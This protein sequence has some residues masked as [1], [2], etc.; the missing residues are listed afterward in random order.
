M[1]NYSSQHRDFLTPEVIFTTSIFKSNFDLKLFEFHEKEIAIIDPQQ[2][3]LLILCH[4]ILKRDQNGKRNES[5]KSVFVG[6]STSE[7]SDLTPRSLNELGS[8][9]SATASAL[10]VASGRVSFCF[11]LRGPSMSIDTACSSSLVAMHLG[12]KSCN[13]DECSASLVCGVNLILLSR[14]TEIFQR[15]GMLSRDGRCKTL[16][17]TADGYVRSEGCE[18]L[19]LIRGY[20]GLHTV[21]VSGSAVNQ[22]GRS[23]SLTA[24][25]GPSQRVVIET[26]LENA[27]ADA[28]SLSK[29]YMHGT[30]TSLGD[31]IEIGGILSVVGHFDR[32]KFSISAVKTY[33]GH[34]ECASG[35]SSILCAVQQLEYSHRYDTTIISQNVSIHE[36]EIQR[37]RE[38]TWRENCTTYGIIH[39]AGILRDASI[40]RQSPEIVRAVFAPK[41]VGYKNIINPINAN[42]FTIAFS[43]ITAQIPSIGQ[44]NYSSANAT[45]DVLVTKNF[46]SGLPVCSI[47]WG[48][49]DIYEI[50]SQAVF[51]TIGK[52]V[53]A[54]QPLM[55]A[56]IDSLVAS[57]L[58]N[59]LSTLLNIFIPTTIAF[60]YPTMMDPQQRLLLMEVLNSK[61]CVK[62]LTDCSEILP[63]V[64]VY[65]GITSNYFNISFVTKFTHYSATGQ[66]PSVASGR[67]SYIFGWIGPAL[68]IDTACSSSLVG[69]HQGFIYC[70]T[71]EYTTRK[72][73]VC[74]GCHIITSQ[75]STMLCDAAGMLSTDGR[76][77]ALDD[78]ADGYVRGEA[79][80][81][82]TIERKENVMKSSC[83][84]TTTVNQDGRSSALTAP[85]GYAQYSII[86]ESLNSICTDAKVA[87]NGAELH[88]TGTV[89]GDPIEL[90]SIQKA[91]LHYGK[92]NEAIV[93]SAI[94]S[95]LG[96]GETGAGI[97]SLLCGLKKTFKL[98]RWFGFMMYFTSGTSG[99]SKGVIL[100]HNSICNHSVGVTDAMRLTR[101]DI[102]LHAAPMF[103]L[104]DAFAIYAITSVGGSHILQEE[105]DAVDTLRIIENEGVTALNLSSTMLSIID[106]NPIL[107]VLDLSS[108]RIISCGGSSFPSSVARH[109]LA[110]LGCEF[111]ISYGMTECCGKVSMSIL[112]IKFRISMPLSEQMRA[113]LSSGRPFALQNIRIV[114]NYSEESAQE[115]KCVIPGSSEVGEVQCKGPTAIKNY[116]NFRHENKFTRDGWLRTGD[117]AMVDSRGFL[118]ILDR[119]IDMV[120]IGSENVYCSEVEAALLEH[121]SIVQAAVFGIPNAILGEELC[122]YVMWGKSYVSKSSLKDIYSFMRSRVADFKVPSVIRIVHKIPMNYAQMC[123]LSVNLSN[124]IRAKFGVFI[125]I[126]QFEYGFSLLQTEKYLPTSFAIGNSHSVSSGRISFFFDFK[127]PSISVDTACSSSHV[128][129][130]LLRNSLLKFET[131]AGISGS[132]N[133]C[134]NRKL[135]M[136]FSES[137]MLSVDGRCKVLD[138][139]ADGYVR[140]EFCGVIFAVS[141]TKNNSELVKPQIG[142]TVMNQDGLSSSLTAP[143]GSSQRALIGEVLR[144]EYMNIT[145]Q[146][147]H[148][149][150]TGTPLGDPIEINA[151]SDVMDCKK[152]RKLIPLNLSAIK[153]SLGHAEVAA[154]MISIISLISELEL[155]E[156]NYILHLRSINEHLNVQSFNSIMNSKVY[157][158]YP[159]INDDCRGVDRF[160]LCSSIV[161]LLGS[162]G[163]SNYAAANSWL[164]TYSN[165]RSYLGIN[166]ISIQWG[167]WCCQQ[168]MATFKV[169]ARMIRLGLGVISSKVGLIA[170][171]KILSTTTFPSLIENGVDSLA[172]VEISNLIGAEFGVTLPDIGVFVGISSSD[173][174]RMLNIQIDDISPFAASGGAFSVAAGR[175]SFCFAL[176]GPS[177]A[178]DTACSS[179]LV[180]LHVCIRISSTTCECKGNIVTGVNLIQLLDTTLIFVSAGMISKD[181]R[182]K[183]L[184][185]SADGYV[186]SE[187]CSS[188][189][190]Q[191]DIS[192]PNIYTNIDMYVAISGSCVNQ[193]GR[194]SSLNAPS[195]LAQRDCIKHVIHM[196]RHM[197]KSDENTPI[198]SLHGTG[199][200]LGDPIETSAIQKILYEEFLDGVKTC[201]RPMNRFV[202]LAATKSRLGHSE[203]ASGILSV[204]HAIGGLSRIAQ[205]VFYS[206][207]QNHDFY[208]YELISRNAQKNT[209]YFTSSK[210]CISVQ[211]VDVAMKADSYDSYQRT[212]ATLDVLTHA[213]GSLCDALAYNQSI[214][215]FSQVLSPKV[216]GL[217]TVSSWLSTIPIKKL[218]IFSSIS[219]TLG[220]MSQSNYAAANGWMDSWS[221]RNYSSGLNVISIEWGAWNI[222]GGMANNSVLKNSESVEMECSSIDPQH[223]ILLEVVQNARAQ[224]SMLLSQ[225]GKDGVIVGI[226]SNEFCQISTMVPKSL[227][228]TGGFLSV[229]CGRISYVYNF[230]GP[231]MCIDTA[232]SSSLVSLHLSNRTLTKLLIRIFSGGVNI[233]LLQSTSSMFASAG[234]LSSDGRCKVLDALA[235]GYVRSEECIIALLANFQEKDHIVIEV[236][237]S[238]VSQDGRSSSLTAPNGPSQKDC[239]NMAIADISEKVEVLEFFTFDLLQLHG[240]GTALGDPIEFGAL[241]GLNNVTSKNEP[242]VVSAS[243][244]RSGHKE[245]ASGLFGLLYD[246]LLNRQNCASLRVTNAPKIDSMMHLVSFIRLFPLSIITMSSISSLLVSPGQLNYAASNK[247]MNSWV[248]KINVQG[249]VGLSIKFGAWNGIEG[250]ATKSTISRLEKGGV[251]YLSANEAIIGDVQK[252]LEINEPFMDSGLDSLGLLELRQSVM[253]HFD[254]DLPST[255]SFDYPTVGELSKYILSLMS[256]KNCVNTEIDTIKAK[257]E[258]K[259]EKFTFSSLILFVGVL[260]PGFV[261]EIESFWNVLMSG[262][263]NIESI[264]QRRFDRELCG[265][266]GRFAAFL[267]QICYF[268]SIL[269]RYSFQESREMD[270]QQRILLESCLKYFT[271]S[272]KT[273]GYFQGYQIGIYLGVMWTE[274]QHLLRFINPDRKSIYLGTGNGLSF[275]LGR[276]SFVFGLNGP[277]CITDT[278]CSS[279]LVALHLSQHALMSAECIEA[280]VGGIQCMIL[281]ETFMIMNNLKALSS[282]SRCKTLDVSANGYGRGEGTT[283]LYLGSYDEESLQWHIIRIRGSSVNQDGRS[284]SFTS[285]Y[286]PSQQNLIKD[287]LK[288]SNL[289]YVAGL[290]SLH[291]TGTSLGDPIE[292]SALKEVC[293][294]DSSQYLTFASSKSFFGHTEGAAGLTGLIL[295]CASIFHSACPE[296][297]FCRNL[298]PHMIPNIRGFISDLTPIPLR[299]QDIFRHSKELRIAVKA[300]GLNFRDILNVLGMYPGDPG[301]PGSDF[302]GTVLTNQSSFKIG[303]SVF[304]LSAGCLGTIVEVLQTNCAHKPPNISHASAAALPTAMIT[305][306]LILEKLNNLD[307]IQEISHNLDRTVLLHG[308]SGGVGLTTAQLLISNGYTVIGSAS[309]ARKRF[310]MRTLGFNKMTC[311]RTTDFVDSVTTNTLGVGV[312][313]VINSL[314]SPGMIAASLSVLQRNGSFIEIGKREI[315]S[316]RAANLEKPT[317]E[318]NLIATDFLSPRDIEAR[319]HYL[320]CALCIGTMKP[321]PSQINNFNAV[322]ESMR[323]MAH[324]N[325]IGKIIV[326]KASFKENLSLKL[327]IFGGLGYLGRLMTMWSN[328]NQVRKV[329]L[330]SRLARFRKIQ[331]NLFCT[332]ALMGISK[333]KI[334]SFEEVRQISSIH[335]SFGNTIVNASGLLRDGT[336]ELQSFNT[337]SIVITPKCSGMHRVIK[338][339]ESR[340]PI[341][342]YIFFSSI[343]TFLASPGQINYV[344][345]NASLDNHARTIQIRGH[346]CVSIQWGGWEGD[347][348]MANS[349]QIVK[350]KRS[351]IGSINPMI[352]L[353]LLDITIASLECTIS[354][355]TEC[356]S[357]INPFDW[358]TVGDDEPLVQSGIDSLGAIEL[359]NSLSRITNIDL[360]STLIFDHPTISSIASH[361]EQHSMIEKNSQ[362]FNENSLSL[363][364]EDDAE[365]A[366]NYQTIEK[367]SYSM[368]EIYT[369]I[370]DH[371][372][373]VPYERW[374]IDDN[375]STLSSRFGFFLLNIESF[376]TEIFRV[377]PPEATLMDPQQRILLSLVYN[378]KSCKNVMYTQRTGVTVG[379]SGSEYGRL[380]SAVNV[381]TATGG[382]LS[383][384]SGRISYIFGLQGICVSVDTACSS[385]L[386]GLHLAISNMVISE[387]DASISCGSNVTLSNVTT[388]MFNRAGMLSIDGRC[389]VLD[390]KAD[391]YVRGEACV[392]L[393]M[394]TL[395]NSEESMHGPQIGGSATNQDG[396]SSSLTA[397][398]GPSQQRVIRSALQSDEDALI[399]RMEGIELHGTGTSLGDPIEVGAICA[400]FTEHSQRSLVVSAAKSFVGH[401]EPASGIVGLIFSANNIQARSFQTIL[402]LQ[403]VNF[404]LIQVQVC[405]H[406][407]RMKKIP[408]SFLVHFRLQG[409]CLIASFQIKMCLAL[410]LYNHQRYKELQ[411]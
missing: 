341:Q 169:C 337:I 57:E 298:N 60:D 291:G 208:H 118:T 121:D 140:Q 73:A 281:A 250:M 258:K 146:G 238:A 285:P 374:S 336:I 166:T 293:H 211:K 335:R 123:F 130:H 194:S 9:Y 86:K 226:S 165:Y 339:F 133:L 10:S 326:T 127:G 230:T 125:A 145:L 265:A 137:G 69:V 310:L 259:D 93:L 404:Y 379:I 229:A 175:L 260:L 254:I 75:W 100:N 309:S 164:D 399:V 98:H 115:V 151:L 58:A 372:T 46:T 54:E 375:K 124:C 393:F 252:S 243:K 224:A 381:Y 20:D 332:T 122:A 23:S 31:P 314:T 369:K 377:S 198:F 327:L 402:H 156:K 378:L 325:H 248:Y 279:S 167:A 102:W 408:H 179:S 81:I 288:K 333:C 361:I 79:I 39:T 34:S 126:S 197:N 113:L 209:A 101:S 263:E 35:I 269:F 350:M 83:V 217:S 106:K 246:G 91:I 107:H 201:N 367:C 71:A 297:R 407:E 138:A 19:H 134:L 72:K 80:E 295:A 397:P 207:V 120:L 188:I 204:V 373:P 236:K 352:G 219:S 40:F 128:A 52:D 174:A 84:M 152:A 360:P 110:R 183:V 11:D 178:V 30:G 396:R 14:T 343:A 318:I 405:I 116:W 74:S 17:S 139:S 409:Y 220:I 222:T 319:M 315:W 323:E 213:A 13:Q 301:N 181:G 141:G 398:N 329:S 53:G 395:K 36:T 294:K 142:K 270:P 132:V 403:T 8:A 92:K 4:P 239:I 300:V 283:L 136:V 87:I 255:V 274:Y 210:C 199:T 90:G 162:S 159:Y 144:A 191:K 172:A 12:A 182:C 342:N 15:A 241:H 177:I 340:A 27:C 299:N 384:A 264:P 37:F 131:S 280:F 50:V 62:K 85:N 153:S 247:Y 32:M 328:I 268:D 148:I 24:P 234:M 171:N 163:Q 411:T 168:S 45:L 185:Q 366:K 96:H 192:K 117:L 95:L 321:I 383:V 109:I 5:S 176:S 160:T 206:G 354:P 346:A 330:L 105:F 311:T 42:L 376:D 78:R 147:V 390:A 108:I 278:A 158:F 157:L 111:F 308:A 334:E 284:S 186:R 275:L 322:R 119:R 202:H 302:S 286:G 262:I 190:M 351:G 305:A 212:Y 237:G 245:P 89:L 272:R 21:I 7:Y 214:N 48:A 112:D 256:P 66:Q 231:S 26:A 368:L 382:A 215:T 312:H 273:V 240:T 316:P 401:T 394:N 261:S 67:L 97:T 363:S 355:N 344:A 307:P 233:T 68:S 320:S 64:G 104:V 149:H 3:I 129:L 99:N 43:S 292:V 251:G 216:K 253:Q 196:S 59:T 51:G 353:R 387:C 388:E 94:K 306:D 359:R 2:R 289:N 357:I 235:D 386:V 154:G 103:H 228:A 76:C 348:G 392:A 317:C 347:G 29:F 296:M 82:L 28:C 135:N 38:L 114:S 338:S 282:D 290:I 77:K 18:V 232:C 391:G 161:S 63:E 400:V 345:A 242:L 70:N 362:N 6:I 49:W 205:L 227:K 61:A 385:S 365:I 271:S 55:E 56:G 44:A 221:C 364:V 195:G 380:A 41:V 257:Q 150:G 88:G 277:S 266:D 1:T 349:V 22:D 187:S 389:K 324:A 287:A 33:F 189:F 249:I 276:P 173:H 406:A 143:N 203:P 244:S 356:L 267:P 16:D 410:H 313:S 218:I 358:S 225:S 180:A 25:N 223:R 184:D 47:R 331:P 200:A 170:L 65:I 304:G 303:E 193:D 370:Q 371:I 155:S